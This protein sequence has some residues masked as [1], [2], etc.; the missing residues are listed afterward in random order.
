MRSSRT[1]LC[2]FIFAGLIGPAQASP[3]APQ[4]TVDFAMVRVPHK[5]AFSDRV[6]ILEFFSFPCPHCN[7]FDPRLDAWARTRPNDVRIRRI[8]VAFGR[9]G[10]VHQRL[11]YT[12]EVLGK[13]DALRPAVFKAIHD[14]ANKLRN[15]EAVFDFAA[16]HGIDRQRFIATYRSAEVESRVK[17]AAAAEE[18]YRVGQIPIVFVNGKY[19]TAPFF[20]HKQPSLYERVSGFFRGHAQR[21]AREQ[22]SAMRVI[23]ALVNKELTETPRTGDPQRAR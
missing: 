5:V 17:A 1:M 15:E 18:R 10:D 3:D 12:L 14:D 9:K 6:E 20:F 16:A 21:D 4:S 11:Y 19:V 7:G 23:D 13:V 8:H 22:D 2:A